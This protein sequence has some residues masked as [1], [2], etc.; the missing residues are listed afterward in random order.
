M[1][2]FDTGT[3]LGI[4]VA[5]CLLAACLAVIYNELRKFEYAQVYHPSKEIIPWNNPNQVER[6][7]VHFNSADGIRLNGC[8]FPAAPNSPKKQTAL[9]VCH[10]NGGNISYLEALYRQLAQ[11]G[12][13]VLLFDY[14]GYGFSEGQ[15][16][17]EG[18]Y[19]DA[20]AAYQWLRQSGFAATNIFVY[21]ESLGGA[22]AAELVLREPAGGLILEGTPTSIADIGVARYPW[23]PVRLVNHIKYNTRAK[24]ARVKVPVLIMHSRDDQVVPYP[25]ARQNFAAVNGSQKVFW[26]LKGGHVAAGED[27]HQGLDKFFFTLE[28]MRTRGH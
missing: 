18:T 25:M 26:D 13:N 9:L 17:E 5:L 7:E 12:A 16:D 3:K 11:T 1:A 22:I 19:R 23:L 10:G 15:P 28:L 14:R 27:Y 21:G 2:K 6:Q 20:Q 4:L 24:L 8:F